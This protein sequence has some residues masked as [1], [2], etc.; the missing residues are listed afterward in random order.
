MILNMRP[1]KIGAEKRW[2]KY[3]IE[4]FYGDLSLG[5]ATM[6]RIGCFWTKGRLFLAIEGRGA[7]TFHNWVHRGYVQEKIGLMEGDAAN[8]ADFLNAQLGHPEDLQGYYNE[9]SCGD[10]E[11]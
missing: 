1:N 3:D 10:W 2:P 7:Y 8:V 6:F 9:R 4:T 11:G 5:N